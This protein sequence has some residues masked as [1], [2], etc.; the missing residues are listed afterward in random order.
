LRQ[1]P[2]HFLAVRIAG[3]GT[4][5]REE[6]VGDQVATPGI[7]PIDTLQDVDLD[8]A[9]LDLNLAAPSVRPRPVNVYEILR[10]GWRET[11]V[12]MTLQ[13]F[14][15][16]SER[17][18]LGSLVIDALLTCLD[19]APIIGSAGK[20]SK[21]LA[22]DDFLGSEEWEIGT[23]VG[24]IDVLATNTAL[25]IAIVLENKIAHQLNNPL[26]HY[27][28][29]AFSRGD[30]PTLL[31]VVLA[32]ELR[33]A[34]PQLDPWLSRSITYAELAT[35]IKRMPDLVDHLLNPSDQDQRR[36]LE[37]LQQFIEARSGDHDVID[38]ET[39]ATRL[40]EW[41]E[42]VDRH[43][44]AIAKFEEEKHSI[45][46]MLRLRSKRLIDPL[47][48]RIASAGLEFS[49]EAHGDYVKGS[50]FWNAYC[51]TPE[52]W[53]IELKFAGAPPQPAI[54]VADY[55]GRTYKDLT[56][57]PLG[58]DWSASDEQI[59]DAFIEQVKFILAQ[60]RHGT[61]YQGSPGS[62]TPSQPA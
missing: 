2:D 18:G 26:D 50:D 40:N 14:L 41:R 38:L 48:D 57:E 16:P 52:D 1:E 37:L 9:F 39:E 21:T 49:W 4:H 58:L 46:Q 24:F 12:D 45:T 17:H 6:R 60:V 7:R 43:R 54:Y 44:E 27:A 47:A 61:R 32:P 53:S 25:G 62:S 31:V 35:A 5:R 20:T 51:F 13:F 8:L 29:V 55:R 59:A 11:R 23:Q 56:T 10:E 33:S 36:S 19:G 30:F 15:D 28:K 22:S 42:L 34:K 3:R